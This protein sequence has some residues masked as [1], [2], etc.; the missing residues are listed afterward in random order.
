MG[1]IHSCHHLKTQRVMDHQTGN[2]SNGSGVRPDSGSA[3]YPL[4]LEADEALIVIALQL[5]WCLAGQGAE[6]CGG[7]PRLQHVDEALQGGQTSSRGWS[8]LLLQVV[9]LFLSEVNKN[10]QGERQLRM[11]VWCP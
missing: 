4:L 10:L 3:T 1:Q 6:L 2:S 8:L 7:R 9:A 11:I 5:L